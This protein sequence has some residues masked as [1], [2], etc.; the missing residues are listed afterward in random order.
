MRKIYAS[1]I[2]FAL[3][4]SLSVTIKPVA[5]GATSVIVD[6]SITEYSGNAVGQ[7]FT[8]AIKIAD[9]TN[10]FGFDIKFRWNTTY[11][12]FVSRS[13]RVPKDA[14][15]DGV[16]WN[17]VINVTDQVN[18]S[19]GTYWIAIASMWPAPT[20]N[21]S[22]TVFTITLQII[23]Q[24]VSP[25]PDANTTLQLYSTDLSNNI[26]DPIPHSTQDG[27][28]ILHALT[29]RRDVAVMNV[30]PSRTVLG[31]GFKC[32]ITITVTNQGDFPETFNVTAY[33]NTTTIQTQTP[34]LTNG[35]SANITFTWNTV[36]F[37]YG[38]YTISAYAWPVQN[39]TDTADN[40]LTGG[41]VCVGIPGD[42]K[43]DGTVNILDAIILGNHFLETPSSMGWNQGGNNADING[44][45]VVNIL[46]AIVLGNHF[47]EQQLYDP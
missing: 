30:K 15:P 24:P 6:P 18:T 29:A 44:D 25:E 43:Y 12:A 37:A 32:N 36:G 3:L 41:T 8:V 39:E 9:V 4:L 28:V 40:N 22:G 20:F 5:S 21:G 10:L 45:N 19:D 42:I 33:A 26:G 27:A 7:Q 46:D 16:L 1:V 13:I 17:P 35:T 47:L 14:C 31:Q 38:N 2:V 11:L 23:N 34:T